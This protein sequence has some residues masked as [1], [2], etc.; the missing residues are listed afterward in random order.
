MSSILFKIRFFIL[1]SATIFGVAL[2]LFL[3]SAIEWQTISAEIKDSL[4]LE[5]Y[6]KSIKPRKKQI[7]KLVEWRKKIEPISRKEALSSVIQSINN[8]QY[9]GFSRKVRN[10]LKEEKKY[11]KT[12]NEKLYCDQRENSYISIQLRF[13]LFY[14]YALYSYLRSK[15]NI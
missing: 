12:L 9:K 2:V 11:R 10:S 13:L 8:R 7:K 3:D 4:Q 15:K 5:N 14:C 6:I 1:F